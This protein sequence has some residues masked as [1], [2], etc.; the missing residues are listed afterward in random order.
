MELSP[1]GSSWVV[2][3]GGLTG[4]DFIPMKFC[5]AT[6]LPCAPGRDLVW[7]GWWE[8][9]GR[10]TRSGRCSSFAMRTASDYLPRLARA[11]RRVQR[12]RRGFFDAAHSGS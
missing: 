6:E 5:G 4:V 3:A 1:V 10:C 12:P 8:A 11:A 7:E 9:H 2:V